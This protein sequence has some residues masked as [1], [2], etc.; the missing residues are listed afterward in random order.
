MRGLLA[1]VGL[2]LH[3]LAGL[4]PFVSRA[5][6]RYALRRGQRPSTVTDLSELLHRLISLSFP[7]SQHRVLG[8][9]RAKATLD[10]VK[11]V[12]L[13]QAIEMCEVGPTDRL[14]CKM[15]CEGSEFEIL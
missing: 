14:V 9:N 8:L 13:P 3:S 1:V 11:M 10:R 5:A 7:E 12:T 15:N 4:R 2:N 6:Y